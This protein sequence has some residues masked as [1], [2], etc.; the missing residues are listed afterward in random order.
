M[1]VILATV[2]RM[3]RGY[4]AGAKMGAERVVGKIAT[5]ILVR[6]GLCLEPR[7][8]ASETGYKT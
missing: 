6:D 2:L 8:K 3:D 1:I 5:I 4:G 7:C